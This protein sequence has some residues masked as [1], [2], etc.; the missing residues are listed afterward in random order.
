MRAICIAVAIAVLSTPAMACGITQIGNYK[1]VEH[2]ARKGFEEWINSV[3]MRNAELPP[4]DRWY[5]EVDYNPP[6]DEP[7]ER[8]HCLDGGGGL[9]C[10]TSVQTFSER[11]SSRDPDW[12]HWLA[13]HLFPFIEY[14]I[15][16]NAV[17]DEVPWNAAEVIAE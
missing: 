3:R 5:F 10:Y 16:Y 6:I 12:R 2:V 17:G 8:P 11:T 7:I 15:Y 13:T 9:L 4:S 14:R 1:H